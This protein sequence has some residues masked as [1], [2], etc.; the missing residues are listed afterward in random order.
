MGHRLGAGETGLTATRLLETSLLR[1]TRPMLRVETRVTPGVPLALCS[2]VLLPLAL[3]NDFYQHGNPLVGLVALAPLFAAFAL[4]PS[5]RAASALGALFGA[6]STFLIHYWLLYFHEFSVWTISGV[7]L[8]Y[9]VYLALLGP[10]LRA[11]ALRMRG[12]RPLALGAAW[13]VYEYI[14][15]SGFLGFPWGL[16]A[17]PF[18]D[19]LPLTQ[20]ASVYGVWGVS[21]LV[22]CVNALAAEQ[23][24]RAIAARA[25]LPP[26]RT[27]RLGGVVLFAVALA[28]GYGAWRM[29][30]PPAESGRVTLALVQH[31][32]DPWQA[33]NDFAAVGEAQEL[34]RQAI[35]AG[36]V[37]V[38]VW[39]E[40]IIPYLVRERQLAGFLERFP[41]PV[42][43]SMF[44]R[45]IRTPL[46]LGSPFQADGEAGYENAALLLGQDGRL[47]GRYGKQQLV[48]M[49]ERVPFWGLEPVRSF[50]EGALGLTEGWTPGRGP[51]ILTAPLA[52]GGQVR[53]AT[54]I[55]F[56]DAFPDLCR[57]MVRAGAQVLVNMT[58]VSWSRRESA[59]VQMLVAAR[60]RGIEN[61]CALVRATNGGVTAVIGLHGEI[62]AELPLFEPGVLRVDIPL[63]EGSGKTPYAVLGDILPILLACLLAAG[64]AVGLLRDGSRENDLPCRPAAPEAGHGGPPGRPARRQP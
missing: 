6:V 46:L 22:A 30:C 27:A 28:G 1:Y 58:N 34:T 44:L 51:A 39:G 5:S 23:I 48:P 64:I 53:V 4:S 61:G 20:V 18:S 49:A 45:E 13:T 50:F 26:S 25:S 24:L 2:A 57:R 37:D 47:L 7:V 41:R 42:S 33:G 3:P 14:K 62:T 11:V 55:C 60:F 54:P 15:S 40:T 29:A 8:G 9:T 36:P 16:I 32:A 63:Y 17:H 19:V 21:L 56:E 52:R 59:M 10:V 35:A 38:V 43:L 12:V 31:N